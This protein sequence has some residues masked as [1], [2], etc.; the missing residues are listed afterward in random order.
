MI[1]VGN[2]IREI[3]TAANND[4]V[5][6]YL[7]AINPKGIVRTVLKTDSN[8]SINPHSMVVSPISSVT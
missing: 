3:I 7:S 5:L 8:R 4:L 6:P 2:E 1:R